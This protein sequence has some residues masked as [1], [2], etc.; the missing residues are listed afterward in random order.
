VAHGLKCKCGGRGK[1]GP[2]QWGSHYI[3]VRRRNRQKE[4]ETPKDPMR[5]Y[6]QKGS[7]N[8]KVTS[9]QK[10]ERMAYI[11]TTFVQPR[12]RAPRTQAATDYTS[13]YNEAKTNLQDLSKIICSK[14]QCNI[15]RNSS[16]SEKK[17]N[18][19]YHWF[20]HMPFDLMG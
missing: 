19:S 18:S 6:I 3:N 8:T 16:L 9:S 5:R 4:N 15:H 11:H 1:N 17:R 13:V 7:R 20:H 10:P 2:A 12:L 14:C